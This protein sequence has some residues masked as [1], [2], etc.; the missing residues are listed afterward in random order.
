M[1][2]LNDLDAEDPAFRQA[3]LLGVISGCIVSAPIVAALGEDGLER[4][5]ERVFEPGELRPP[6]GRS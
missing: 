1:Y 5:M 4:I 2:D 6:V 3:W